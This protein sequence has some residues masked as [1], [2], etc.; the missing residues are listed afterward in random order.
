M[1]PVCVSLWNR[2]MVSQGW[3]GGD[4][5]IDLQGQ[6]SPKGVPVVEVREDKFQC[7]YHC[8]YPL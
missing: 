4:E 1:L 6:S 7:S 3:A 5:G 8:L 2:T